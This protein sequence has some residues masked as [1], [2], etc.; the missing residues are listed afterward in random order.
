MTRVAIEYVILQKKLKKD[1]KELQGYINQIKAMEKWHKQ[2]ISVLKGPSPFSGT[3]SKTER[4]ILN[5]E[6]EN[7][8]KLANKM[9]KER[10]SQMKTLA[11]I[12]K[13]KKHN[14]IIQLVTMSKLN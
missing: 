10:R 4:N 13:R 6:Y 14:S 8:K 3:P 1:M 5:A 2:R 12:Y 9:I 7:I 11:N